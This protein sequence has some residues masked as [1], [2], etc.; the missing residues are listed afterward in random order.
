M[1]KGIMR[2]YPCKKKVTS[3]DVRSIIKETIGNVREEGE[4]FICS[5][6]PIEEI[7]IRIKSNKEIEVET[8]TSPSE[9]AESA[10][11]KYNELIEKIT[12]Y[13]AKE[14]KKLLMKS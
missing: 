13:S 4:F 10:I 8:K 5:Y 6:S 7:R 9:N 12:G 1:D 11:K 2:T 3:D 14:R